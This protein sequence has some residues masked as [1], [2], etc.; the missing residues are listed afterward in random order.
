LGN[1]IKRQT[2]C[3]AKVPSAVISFFSI[4]F[5]T[6][7]YDMIGRCDPNIAC[8]DEN[9]EMF[10]VKDPTTL[11]KTIIPKYFDH[12]NFSSF[13]R[14]LNFYGFRKICHFLDADES[15]ANHVKFYHKHFSKARPDHLANIKRSTMTNNGVKSANKEVEALKTTVAAL[16][17][18]IAQLEEK[19]EQMRELFDKNK[20]QCTCNERTKRQKTGENKSNNLLPLPITTLDPTKTSIQTSLH[21][22]DATQSTGNGVKSEAGNKT[23]NVQRESS[24]DPYI[25]NKTWNMAR[26][27]SVDPSIINSIIKGDFNSELFSDELPDFDTYEIEQIDKK[28]YGTLGPLPPSLC[29]MPELGVIRFLSDLSIGRSQSFGRKQDSKNQ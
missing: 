14:Q 3:L 13:S 28:P 1:A 21:S 16:E 25:I 15:N 18:R 6:E 27:S 7:T 26:E 10:I 23:W 19:M 2:D 8:W 12:S 22:C 4:S 11:A 20:C 29:N 24:V 9:G 17:D 5:F